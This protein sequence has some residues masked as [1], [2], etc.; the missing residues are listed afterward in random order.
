[1]PLDP[2][3]KENWEKLQTEYDYPVDAMGRPIDQNDTETLRVWRDEG[4]DQFMNQ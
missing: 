2:N 4:I 3:V 1:M